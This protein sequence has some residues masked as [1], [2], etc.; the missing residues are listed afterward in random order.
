MSSSVKVVSSALCFGLFGT[1]FYALAKSNPV[2]VEKRDGVYGF[3]SCN[4]LPDEA[5]PTTLLLN[6]RVANNGKTIRLETPYTTDFMTELDVL[7]N[8]FGVHGR[9]TFFISVGG[10]VSGSFESSPQG[11]ATQLTLFTAGSEQCQL[12]R[13]KRYKFSS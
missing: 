8:G 3:V 1:S 13:H 6:L 4:Y 10:T 2:P 7:V 9:N 11:I 12:L 5:G